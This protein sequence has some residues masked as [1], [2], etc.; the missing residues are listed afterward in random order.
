MHDIRSPDNSPLLSI[1][2]L[3]RWFDRDV[4]RALTGESEVE[5]EALLISDLVTPTAE[6]AGAYQLREDIR[7]DELARLRAERPSAESTWHQRI[8]DY[9][10]RLMQESESDDQHLADEEE[11]LYHLGELF[12]IIAAR[13]EWHSF[14]EY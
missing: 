8:F 13:Q 3:L 1:C 2:A 11:V 5:I 9:F 6:P 7:A 12:L 14:A 4:L 10:L